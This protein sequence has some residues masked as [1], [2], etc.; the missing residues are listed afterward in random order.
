VVLVGGVN[1]SVFVVMG[2]LDLPALTGSDV[3]DIVIVRV[4]SHDVVL[5][6]VGRVGIDKEMPT[7]SSIVGRVDAALIEE[8]AVVRVLVGEFDVGDRVESVVSTVDIFDRSPALA[9][10]P[11]ALRVSHVERVEHRVWIGRMDPKHVDVS[12]HPG[13]EMLPL[14]SRIGGDAFRP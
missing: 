14:D 12:G 4:H 9:T 5:L 2:V 11:G 10:I 7:P 13:A 6:G 3:P 8:E 1:D